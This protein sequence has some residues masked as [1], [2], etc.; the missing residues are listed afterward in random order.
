MKQFTA[1]INKEISEADLHEH[2]KVYGDNAILR[3]S[4]FHQTAIDDHPELLAALK[5]LLSRL[6]IDPGKWAH[7]VGRKYSLYDVLIKIKNIHRH[8]TDLEI[9]LFIDLIEN[10]AGFLT[11]SVVFYTILILLVITFLVA[12]FPPALMIFHYLTNPA[13]GLPYLGFLFTT[14]T[15]SYDFV[16]NL[17]EKKKSI[18]ERIYDAVFLGANF[19][20][21]SSAYILWIIA[22][23]PMTPMIVALFVAASAVN[24]V[25]EVFYAYQIYSVYKQRPKMNANY[26]VEERQISMRLEGSYIKHRNAAILNFVASLVLLGLM[27]AWC[28]APGGA[29]VVIGIVV[30]I[31]V[32]HLVRNFLHKWNEVRT[33]G[34]LARRL[35]ELDLVTNTPINFIKD[36]EFINAP[37]KQA[38]SLV[39]EKKPQAVAVEK[40]LSWM[41]YFGFFG[42]VTSEPEE[43]ASENEE[44]VGWALRDPHKFS[45]FSQQAEQL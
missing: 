28:L 21:N 44:N 5:N 20:L 3:H 14:I 26:S 40:K 23:A 45:I 4:V 33:R 11:R 24:V 12:F 37:A 17:F 35:I 22:A 16:S 6:H 8:Q 25:K 36:L 19:V 41:E 15:T 34:K 18:L 10:K 1:F 13:Q 29:P 30:V 9:D 32:V 42:A 7:Y 38:K 2:M 39:V 31:I 27:S 43:I